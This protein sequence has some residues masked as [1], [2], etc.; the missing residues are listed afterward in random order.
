MSLGLT[1]E[2]L[3]AAYD[4]LRMTEPFDGWDLP[5]GEAVAF[6]VIRADDKY[7]DCETTNSKPPLIRISSRLVGWTDTLVKVMAHEMLHVHLQR[8]DARAKHGPRF[9]KLALEICKHHGFDPKNF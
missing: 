7:G 9:K 2:I 3:R 1:P 8:L 6:A 5:E 4:F